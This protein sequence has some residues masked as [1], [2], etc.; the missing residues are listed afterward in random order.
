MWPILF[1]FS[2]IISVFYHC[3]F[4][5]L[6]QQKT[7]KRR[8]SEQRDWISTTSKVVV[9]N[10]ISNRI[11]IAFGEMGVERQIERE[12]HAQTLT[13]THADIH[14]HAHTI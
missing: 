6:S 1:H 12:T 14:T 5:R 11:L 10:A 3:Q 13:Q 4:L 8:A 2:H 7:T 9:V